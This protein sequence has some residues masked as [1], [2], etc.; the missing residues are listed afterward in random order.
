MS[1]L[2]KEE[3]E[4][5]NDVYQRHMTF[6]QHNATLL[7]IYEGDLLKYVDLDLRKQLHFQSYKE[8]ITRAA[9]INVL[10]KIVDKLSTI[11]KDDP[12]R[13]MVV[14]SA[15]DENLLRWYEKH[16]SVNETMQ[17][18]CD[19]FNLSKSTLI[20]PYV[21]EK[22][23]KPGIRA[24]PNDRF[25]VIG[26]NSV[27]PM[28]PTKVVTFDVFKDGKVI[29]YV[30]T[31]EEIVIFDNNLEVQTGMMSRNDNV[32]G[33]NPLGRIP[34][35]YANASRHLLMPK[36]DSD[37]LRMTK[38]IPILLTDLNYASMY[39]TFSMIYGIDID[40][41]NVV[42]APNAVLKFTS[43]PTSDKTPQIGS[44]KPQVDIDQVLSLVKTELAMWL[45][46]IGVRAGSTGDNDTDFASGISKMIDEM[47]TSEHR[48][49]LSK[50]FA[51]VESRLWSLIM[52]AMH[53]WWVGQRLIDQTAMFS[54]QAEVEIN[55]GDAST[56]SSK[57]QDALN[58]AQVT[59]LM[60]VVE[61]VALGNMPKESAKAVIKAA[62]G[63]NDI[64][65][66][67]IIDPITP[68]SLTPEQV[69]G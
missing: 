53:P 43:D 35:V 28:L 15:S 26:Q 27:D 59:S 12:L 46:S 19:L 24:I 52:H 36:G 13:A 41:T 57:E 20:Q 67:E 49:K 38:L 32:D 18:A 5:V 17:D 16:M 11:Y 42:F 54:S 51:Q 69:D 1:A 45:D 31:D 44:F 40:D 22:A 61:A 25:F 14:E 6:F 9:P 48:V 2:D 4:H 8:A 33:I 23:R 21:D 68:G 39:Q 3:M 34:F 37:R 65:V 30:Y 29:F 50:Y 62:F 56:S 66:D 60:S 55:Y 7:D 64:T 10:T 63:L 47:D 58:G